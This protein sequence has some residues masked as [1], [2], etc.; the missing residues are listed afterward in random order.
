NRLKINFR[1]RLDIFQ[2]SIAR[3]I[4]L[5]SQKS[6]GKTQCHK[7]ASRSFPLLEAFFPDSLLFFFQNAHRRL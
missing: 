1:A 6:Q 3:W 4:S 2:K 7:K 5:K